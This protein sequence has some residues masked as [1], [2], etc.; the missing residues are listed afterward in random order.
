[1]P[2]AG[3]RL[4]TYVRDAM[5]RSERTRTISNLSAAAGLQRA[6]LYA[7]F[8]GRLPKPTTMNA[9]A[10]A[11]DVP[12]GALWSAWDG[13]TATERPDDLVSAI[14]AQTATLQAVE[15]LLEQLLVES[16]EEPL[17]VAADRIRSRR[18]PAHRPAN[19]GER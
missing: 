19:T 11:L 8:R 18:P 7:T 1:M 10:R 6:T 17:A 15:R 5:R 3:E 4:E 13:S 16:D 12:V 9:L 14:R 2:A